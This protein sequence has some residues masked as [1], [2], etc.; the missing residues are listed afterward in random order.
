M[1]FIEWLFSEGV[2]RVKGM[3]LGH[4]YELRHVRDL[5][6]EIINVASSLRVPRLI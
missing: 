2:R 5:E 6:E 3:F 1:C 4:G